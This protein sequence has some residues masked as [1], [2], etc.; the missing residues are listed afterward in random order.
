MLKTFDPVSKSPLTCVVARLDRG[1]LSCL[2]LV[3]VLLIS[4][5]ARVQTTRPL[6]DDARAEQTHTTVKQLVT[7]TSEMD[8]KGN[9]NYTPASFDSSSFLAHRASVR[10]L[11]EDALIGELADGL[12]PETHDRA[13]LTTARHLFA[14]IQAGSLEDVAF[15]ENGWT[16]VTGQ[17]NHQLLL[18]L[19]L[20]G[21]RL[22][23]IQRT[24]GVAFLR[25]RLFGKRSSIAADL[26]LIL[27]SERWV[28][29]DLQADWAA[30]NR[31]QPPPKPVSLPIQD[32][33]SIF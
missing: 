18:G 5:C 3:L 8:Q 28:V 17:I 29:D 26:Y 20:S 22:G 9:T 24:E 10:L 12:D 14:A 32:G 23:Q 25:A 19:K 31:S 27:E 16:H 30:L 2:V 1:A 15:S 4:A 11:P 6:L 33:W 13:A 7:A 21:F